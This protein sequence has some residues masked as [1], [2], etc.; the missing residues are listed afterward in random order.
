[1]SKRL[2][3]EGNVRERADGR[4]EA[5]VYLPDGRRKSVFGATADEA[6]GK[7]MD[8]LEAL[9][10]GLPI[11]SER[12]NT[13]D[14][15]LSWLEGHR[16]EIRAS[17]ASGY[18]SVL[19]NYVLPKIGNIGLSRLAPRDIQNMLAAASDDGKAPR[20]V[21][22]T[23]AVVRMALQQAVA[24]GD[25]P[26]NVADLVKGPK[27]EHDAVNPWDAQECGVFLAGVR[28]DRHEALYVCA[29][30]LGLRQGELVGLRWV[31][32]RLAAGEVRIM[33]A[34]D[35]R[36]GAFGPPKS[37]Q[38]RRVLA[39]PGMTVKALTEHRER[40][41][42]EAEVMGPGWNPAG[43]VFVTALGTPLDGGNVGHYFQRH[44]ARLGL[45]RIRF[46]DLRHS[47]ASLLLAQGVSLREIMEQL[48]HSQIALTANTY[49]HV[50]P[51]MRRNVAV[52]MDAALAGRKSRR[53]QRGGQLRIVS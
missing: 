1:M 13:G 23:R 35:R 25:I 8:V 33:Q 20:T 27:V 51:A 3:G 37:Q 45:R 39:L 47:C 16:G 4:W 15:L 38:S 19:R 42:G 22:L 10:K 11:P 21:Q 28:G 53:G 14:F 48:G 26:R 34:R 29:L 17:T 36:T 43:L 6:N 30:T 46:H 5:R 52:Q 31:D 44:V 24:W 18:E 2:A 40:Q 7:R 50:L 49:T 12:L 41:A 32:V 9:R